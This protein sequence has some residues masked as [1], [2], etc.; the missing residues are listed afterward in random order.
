MLLIH[1]FILIVTTSFCINAGNTESNLSSS[2]PLIKKKCVA[3]SESLTTQ[4]SIPISLDKNKSEITFFDTFLGQRNISLELPPTDTLSEHSLEENKSDAK[5]TPYTTAV[6]T[7]MEPLNNAIKD[8]NTSCQA[9]IATSL[10][11]STKPDTTENRVLITQ[12]NTLT[13]LDKNLSEITSFNTLLKQ[14]SK[15]LTLP[16]TTISEHSLEKKESNTHLACSTTA[17]VSSSANPLNTSDYQSN[18]NNN[19]PF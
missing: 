16:T 18:P 19:L 15:S 8:S 10:Y 13:P 1:L 14:R 2:K 7:G 12:T 5:L 17:I 4:T 6:L 9:M 11:T 3:R